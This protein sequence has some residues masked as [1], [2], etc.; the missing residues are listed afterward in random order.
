MKQVKE[1]V[2]NAGRE[3]LRR[4]LAARTWGNISC[5]VDE[6]T[7]AVTPSGMAYDAITP[8]DIVIVDLATGQCTGKRRPTSELSVH[9]KTYLARPETNA[10]IHTH[11]PFATAL[12][13]GGYENLSAGV[14]A[15]GS[16]GSDRLSENVKEKIAEGYN[17]VLMA[18]HGALVAAKDMYEAF[19]IAESLEKTCKEAFSAKIKEKTAD[20]DKCAKMLTL[21]KSL[22]GYVSILSSPIALTTAEKEKSILTQLDDVAMMCGKEIPSADEENLV[23]CLKEYG[24]ALIKDVGAVCF[25]STEDDIEA[26]EKLVEKACIAFL[27]TSSLGISGQLN[28]KDATELREN[29]LESYSK[30]FNG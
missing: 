3:L 20:K 10:V 15:Y 30:R 11:Q 22:D 25:S 5:R 2:A 24:A 13:L 26:M 8:E 28:E 16:P 6:H 14:A 29:Y 4:G 27:H 17:T 19:S 18:H 9:I 21:A 23:F 12:S 1:L 7:I